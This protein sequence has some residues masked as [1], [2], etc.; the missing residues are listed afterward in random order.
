MAGLARTSEGHWAWPALVGVC[1]V[2]LALRLYALGRY[3][4]DG[5]EIFSL[6]ATSS[7]WSHLV[8][9][10]IHDKSHPPL[11]YVTL[12]L[13]RMMLPADEF[14]IR[15]LSVLF[16]TALI[17]IAFAICRGLR[18]AEPDT[19]LVILLIA[20][21]GELIYYSQHTRMFAMFELSSALSILAFIW[22]IREPVSRRTLIVLSAA[23]LLM[24]YSHYWGWLAI[25]AQFLCILLGWPAKAG[26]FLWSCV[27]AA[28]GFLPWALAIGAAASDQGGLTGQIAWIG[29]G[30]PGLRD[31]AMLL[32]KMNGEIDFEHATAFGLMLFLPPVIAV[33]IHQLKRGARSL[34]D[35][36][37]CGFWTLLVAIPLVLTSLGSYLAQQNL[38]GARHLS[39]IG[40]PYFILI[41]LSITVLPFSAAKTILRCLIVGWAAAAGAFSLAETA[42]DLHWEAIARGIALKDRVPVY[43]TESAVRIPLEYH[44]EH[45][46]AE[47][48]AVSEQPNFGQIPDNRFWFVYRDISWRAAAPEEQCAADG[49]SVEER[50]TTRSERRGRERQEITALLIRTDKASQITTPLW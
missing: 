24:V 41:G 45:S 23:N 3:G 40:I 48:I 16:G 25:A 15:L 20:V 31:Y 32:G 50:L 6:R 4:F 12:W 17:P 7:T 1:A 8:S 11:F 34:F 42:K 36:R 46:A 5:D 14:W 10:A 44:F 22:F 49:R 13:W 33:F 35:M 38:W 37:A 18:L 21:N 47:A 30:V 2:A 28:I 19:T 26:V 43:A 27:A 39:I 9:A 29:S